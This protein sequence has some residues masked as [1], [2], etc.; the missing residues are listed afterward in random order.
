VAIFRGFSHETTHAARKF[1]AEWNIPATLLQSLTTISPLPSDF[2][3]TPHTGQS[4]VEAF[5]A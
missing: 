3:K 1:S 5:C 4:H 2:I